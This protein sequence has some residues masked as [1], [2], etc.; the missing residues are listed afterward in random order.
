MTVK[1]LKNKSTIEGACLGLDSTQGDAMSITIETPRTA[2]CQ[3][4]LKNES[5]AKFSTKMEENPVI[6]LD[7]IDWARNSWTSILQNQGAAAPPQMA[8]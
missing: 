4:E 1:G 5:K 8:V 6:F 3:E 7:E 2:H